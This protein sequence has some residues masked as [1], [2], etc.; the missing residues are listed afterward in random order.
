MNKSLY[1]CMS[2]TQLRRI[3]F[4]CSKSIK[5]KNKAAAILRIRKSRTQQQQVSL[6]GF[7]FNFILEK[8]ILI[9]NTF[10]QNVTRK[11]KGNLKN[12]EAHTI[13]RSYDFS[14]MQIESAGSLS[15]Q[16]R[17]PDRKYNQIFKRR[18]G[19]RKE[20]KTRPRLRIEEPEDV[21][22]SH[23]EQ[24]AKLEIIRDKPLLGQ[25][26]ITK[27]CKGAQS[28]GLNQERAVDP[29]PTSAILQIIARLTIMGVVGMICLLA[30]ILILIACI[31]YPFI[32]IFLI[33]L[34]VN[35]LIY[36]YCCKTD[37]IEDQRRMLLN[38]KAMT[39]DRFGNTL[40]ARTT[41]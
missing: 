27:I 37:T 21:P 13:T 29:M 2:K 18:I 8:F 28:S 32:L 14:S 30:I 17:A 41:L 40:S 23:D 31:K 16:G 26:L 33:L 7:S 39:V 5:S 6:S 36:N 1:Y 25:S 38:R 12:I 24:P 11:T 9:P 19:A 35:C 22:S 10:E 3:A 20:R 15:L 34:T 4:A